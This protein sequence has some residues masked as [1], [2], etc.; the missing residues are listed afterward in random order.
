M[1]R[2]DGVQLD[3]GALR[4]SAQRTWER[5]RRINT[6]QGWTAADDV[7]PPRLATAL[8]TGPYAGVAVDASDLAA[9]RAAYERAR[10]ARNM[11][12]LSGAGVT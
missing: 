7:L 2:G 3:A 4:A 12:A 8:S 1:E 9:A 5:K 11:L 10:A 6:R